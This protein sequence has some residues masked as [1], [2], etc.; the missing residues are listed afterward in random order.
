MDLQEVMVMISEQEQKSGKL[1]QTTLDTAKA[2]FKEH[3]FL[4]I[5]NLF[6]I[7]LIDR[8]SEYYLG[9]LD[10]DQKGDLSVGAQVSHKRYIVPVPLKGPFNDPRVYANS[11]LMPILTSLLGKQAILTSLGSVTSLPGALDQH[12][13]ADYLPIFEEDTAAGSSVPTFAITMGIP[14]VDIDVING[15]TKIWS[16]TH[17]LYPPNCDLYPFTRYLLTGPKGSCYFWDY[18]TLHAGGSNHSEDLRPLLYMAYT[19]RW[20][21]DFLNPDTLI[22]DEDE[23]KKIPEEHKSL[24]AK[25]AAMQ[26]VPL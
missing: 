25:Y 5:E 14:L 4:K 9:G 26:K 22:I 19:R 23:Y 15:P 3:G 2:L 21:N 7:E 17:K 11:L 16:G 10:F 1:L 6:P 18:R 12:I 24:F 13:H 20:F 8:L